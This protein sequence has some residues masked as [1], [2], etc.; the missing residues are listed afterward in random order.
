MPFSPDWTVNGLGRYDWPMFRGRM[1]AQMDFNFTDEYT[2][3]AID[4]PSLIQDDF[5]IANARIGW[6]S[7]DGRW[8]AA[9]WVKNFT[10]TEYAVNAFDTAT[11]SA[12]AIFVPGAPRI[13]GGTLR[14]NWD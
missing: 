11:F 4:H 13:F 2:M 1:H 12:S 6:V 8:E 7:D 3:N 14:F 10:D 5:W 9:A